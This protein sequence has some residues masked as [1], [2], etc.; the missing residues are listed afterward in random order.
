MFWS[1]LLLLRD[2][3]SPSR[4]RTGDIQFRRALD[5]P[6]TRFAARA[7][8]KLRASQRNG[9]FDNFTGKRREVLSQAPLRRDLPHVPWI[10][11]LLAETIAFRIAKEII[12]VTVDCKVE[13]IF[14]SR[15]TNSC[16]LL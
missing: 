13:D 9:P 3:Q 2:F 12:I 10:G 14:V 15:F 6:S 16:S 4:L 8:Y 11:P 7:A 5:N 1:Q